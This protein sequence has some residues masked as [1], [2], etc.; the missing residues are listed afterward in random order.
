M[1]IKELEALFERPFS[2]SLNAL[3]PQFRLSDYR[4][5]VQLTNRDGRRTRSNASAEKYWSPE[6]DQIRISF[7]PV[8]PKAAPRIEPKAPEVEVERV[9]RAPALPEDLCALVR[10]LD[11]AEKRPGYDFVA[12][13]WFRDAV[14]PAVRP[15][16]S[17]ADARSNALRDAID[18]GLVRTNKVPNPKS[19]SFP[20]TAVRLNRSADEAC[21][22]LG[23]SSGEAG[24][25][26][27]PLPIRGEPLSNSILRERR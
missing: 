19:P 24:P 1:T 18:R 4:L 21:A 25:R 20:V 2:Q 3:P 8:T 6:S 5:Q 7:V 12:L 13:K 26:F 9:P 10:Q 22:I 16:W 11:N 27:R 17:D 14:L 23:A 15:E